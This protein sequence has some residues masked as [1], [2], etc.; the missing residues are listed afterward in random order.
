[1][2]WQAIIAVAEII[3][4]IFIIISVFYL[5]K[6]MHLANKQSLSDSLKDATLQYAQQY[7]ETFGTEKR[8]LS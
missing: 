3:G 5:A 6:Q 1:M 8:Q 4:L 2:D 7:K